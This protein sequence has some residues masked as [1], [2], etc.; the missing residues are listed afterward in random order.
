[1]DG[2][3]SKPGLDTQRS[4]QRWITLVYPDRAGKVQQEACNR[5]TSTIYQMNNWI[6]E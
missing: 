3:L 1:M 6:A 4:R 5:M 2:M